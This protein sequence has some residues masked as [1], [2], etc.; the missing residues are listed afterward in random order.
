MIP[1]TDDYGRCWCDSVEV[2]SSHLVANRIFDPYSADAHWIMDYMEDYHFLRSGWHDYPAEQNEKDVFDLGGFSKV[3]PYY[4]RN[5]EIS[6]MRDDVKPFVRS[7][8]NTL[9][10]MVNKETLSLCEHFANVGAGTRPMKPVGSSAKRRS[11]LRP[12]EAT[13]C[14]SRR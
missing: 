1:P 14:G 13:I 9:S 8:F 6:A 5:A 7:Y 3:Q 11:C 12:S 4:V 2:G 10:A